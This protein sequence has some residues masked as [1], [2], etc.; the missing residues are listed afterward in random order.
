MPQYTVS[1]PV[2][3]NISFLDVNYLDQRATF[4]VFGY[5]SDTLTSTCSPSS[6][7]YNLSR[8]QFLVER[9][10]WLNDHETLVENVTKAFILHP[11]AAGEL[12]D[13]SHSSSSPFHP[14]LVPI[15]TI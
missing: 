9:V 2:I 8:V 12:H 6:F 11:I 4:G 3:H 1:A 15:S 14:G 7:G 5:C 13:R 10:T